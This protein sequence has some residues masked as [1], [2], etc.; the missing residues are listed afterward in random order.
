MAILPNVLFACAH[1]LMPM[2][3]GKSAGEVFGILLNSI[4]G[5]VLMGMFF[6]WCKRTGGSL[7]VSV[8]I[9]AMM[10]FGV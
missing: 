10:D 3:Q 6:E 7:W 1:I 4:L 2:V 9:H 8:L 5:Y